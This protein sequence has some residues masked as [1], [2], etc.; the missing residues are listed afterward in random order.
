[1]KKS[2]SVVLPLLNLGL[3]SCGIDTRNWPR[4]E[5][6][7]E[8]NNIQYIDVFLDSQENLTT[9]FIKVDNEVEIDYLYNGL[10]NYPYREKIEKTLDTAE[11]WNKLVFEFYIVDQDF[12]FYRFTYY[13]YA[14]AN[15]KFVFDNGEVHFV[16]G[17]LMAI[18]YDFLD[19]F[20]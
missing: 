20:K 9:H 16:A 8:A 6:P 2:I 18:Y 5:F 3:V 11:Y 1:M 17:N 14:I 13:E 19:K 7:F 4:V 12:S 15:G 10:S